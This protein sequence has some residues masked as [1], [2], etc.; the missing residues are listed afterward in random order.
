MEMRELT[1]EDYDAIIEL[2]RESDLSH[3]PE[4]R[5]SREEMEKQMGLIPE[6]FLG[7]FEGPNL[8]GVVIGTDD[9]RK[10]W[11]NRLAVR[12]DHGRRGIGTALLRE[13]EE[14][15]RRRGNRIIGVLIETPNEASERF[16]EKMGYEPYGSIAYLSK[17]DSDEV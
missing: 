8:V 11:V 1:I 15:L 9:T 7:A 13:M 6:L 4:G 17:R 10:G 2:W 12:P 5:D 16:F 3:R 14:R